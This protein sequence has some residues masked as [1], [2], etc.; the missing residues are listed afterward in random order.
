MEKLIRW[1]DDPED[2]TIIRNKLPKH[3][4]P[5]CGIGRKEKYDST[6]KPRVCCKCFKAFSATEEQW[7]N[8][9]CPL[10]GATGYNGNVSIANPNTFKNVILKIN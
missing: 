8:G 5:S 1:S 3:V 2:T 4:P 9:K 10:C 7:L 6:V